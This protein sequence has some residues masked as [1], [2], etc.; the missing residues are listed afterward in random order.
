MLH[1]VY[2]EMTTDQYN[3]VVIKV[4]A[5]GPNQNYSYKFAVTGTGTFECIEGPVAL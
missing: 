1:H 5:Y 2:P 3:Y 4:Y